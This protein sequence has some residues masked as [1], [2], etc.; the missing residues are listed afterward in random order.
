[1]DKNSVIICTKNRIEDTIKC[2]NSILIQTRLP[3]EVVIVDSSD[4]EELK[5]RLD[6]FRNSNGI[7]FKY[8]YAEANLTKARNIGIDNSVGDIIMFLDDDVIL[9]KEYVENIMDVFDGDSEGKV[10]GV[11][12]ETVTEKQANNFVKRLLRLGNQILV[13]MF[14]L[15]KYG[16]GGF[17][18][19]GIPTVIRSGSVDKVTNIEYLTGCNM[20]FRREVINEFRFDEK[21]PH[22]EDD[23]IAYRVS[24]RYQNIYTPFAKLVHNATP[25]GGY[26][27]RPDRMKK[28]IDGYHHHFKKNLPQDLKHKF[29][30]HI[31]IFGFFVVQLITAIE[32]RDSRGLRGVMS[33]MREVFSRR[34]V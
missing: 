2:I 3:D 34:G 16:D 17:R 26:G 4:T 27:H 25:L 31:A 28:E 12:G 32:K 33:G 29:A 22:W 20:T 18:L 6:S 21:S 5:S 8:I 23:D 10:G 7:T 24:R 11:I 30:F 1:M 19:S 14:F 15:L 9:E 13:T